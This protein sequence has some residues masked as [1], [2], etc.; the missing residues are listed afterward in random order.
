MT[1]F[2]IILAIG[3]VVT[4]GLIIYSMYTAPTDT[5]LWGPEAFIMD[6]DPKTQRE[7]LDRHPELVEAI[8]QYRST[9]IW[10]LPAETISSVI[11]IRDTVYPKHS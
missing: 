2:L 3:F 1:T 9:G 5:E 6:C 7:I 8:D 4:A 11:K 10:S